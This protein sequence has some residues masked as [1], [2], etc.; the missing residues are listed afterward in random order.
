[1]TDLEKQHA[2]NE[3]LEHQRLGRLDDAEDVYR[4][5]I[6]ADPNQ[7]G[8]LN[9]LANILKDTGRIE[10][11]VEVCRGA[12]ALEPGNAE[13]HS[14]L[15][16]KLLFHPEY[17]RAGIFREQCEWDRRHGRRSPPG[18]DRASN[19]NDRLHI[20]YVSPDFYGHAECF[21]VIPLLKSH[22]R[23]QFEVHCYSSVWN[24][25]K[26]T[27]LIRASAD[28]W[29]EVRQLND[30]QLAD[31]IRRDRIDILVDLTMHMAFNRLGVFA[32]RPAPVL[33]AWLAYPG[34]TGLSAMDYRLTDGW[35]DPPGESDA[36]YSER[37]VRLPGTWCC[38][39]PVGDV[40]P[41]AKRNPG[42]VT[43]GCLNN[44]CKLNRPTL[45]LFANVLSSV[46]GSR[47]LLL[48][49]SERQRLQ[50]IDGFAESGI[51][52]GRI[53]FMT[54]RRR[55]EYLRI[56]DRID[57]CLDPLVY[58]GITTTCDAIWMGVPVITRVGSTAPGRAG[59]SILSNVDLPELIGGDDA[60]FV[61]IAAKLAGD[62]GRRSLLRA[63]LRD[64]MIQSPL[65][66]APRFARSVEAAYRGFG[67]ETR[68]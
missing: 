62:F 9:N 43:F 47:L 20:G 45:S 46:A 17:D 24:P 61:S 37:S 66:D 4:R 5:I 38:Y 54:H 25:D 64:R 29:H 44:P 42:P 1:M 18:S 32:Q 28:V 36:F 26:A 8:V 27:D 41:A 31:E 51:D 13:I 21:F 60:Q 59:L 57:I 48:S 56:Y 2:M 58:N 52:P 12:L 35:I 63:S 22:D 49:E 23:K 19:S 40:P 65:M 33:V 67:S 15:C 11:A 7:A 53:E 6:S 39:H 14:S 30:D 16:Y 50:I 68:V 10:E 34:G 3:A 55:G